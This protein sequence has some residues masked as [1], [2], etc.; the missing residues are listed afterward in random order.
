M[1]NTGDIVVDIIATMPLHDNKKISN[2]ISIFN[3]H[4]PHNLLLSSSK[5]GAN[6]IE[7]LFFI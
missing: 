1:T 3:F 7:L 2:E 5:V 4:N 6:E